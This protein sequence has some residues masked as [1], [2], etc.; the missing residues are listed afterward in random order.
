MFRTFY[1]LLLPAEEDPNITRASRALEAAPLQRAMASSALC[2]KI[3]QNR[4]V[5]GPQ[6]PM[7][8]LITLHF[9]LNLV[10]LTIAPHFSALL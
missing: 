9:F 7:P 6:L 4:P 5:C 1:A 3:Q 8:L 10:P 2:Y